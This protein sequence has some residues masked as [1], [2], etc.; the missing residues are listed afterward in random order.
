MDE[1]GGL[2]ILHIL[3]GREEEPAGRVIAAHERGQE[4]KVVRLGG[5]DFSY[6]SLVE[7]I[8]AHDR[9]ISW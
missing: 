2:R 6:E 4:V 1:G 9:V 7:D 3:T 5:R 8:F